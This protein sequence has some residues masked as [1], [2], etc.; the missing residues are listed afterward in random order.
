MYYCILFDLMYICSHSHGHII[1]PDIALIKDC[2]TKATD[3][4]FSWQTVITDCSHKFMQGTEGARTIIEDCLTMMHYECNQWQSWITPYTITFPELSINK[5]PFT[6]EDASVQWQ[7]T[8]IWK[9]SH[10]SG[11]PQ[12]FQ[13][14]LANKKTL[15]WLVV[16]LDK[17]AKI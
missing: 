3:L 11:L 4:V 16:I 6:A 14:S 12:S 5:D 10:F 1:V 7:C 17:T 8:C 2:Q 13:C 15:W 9:S